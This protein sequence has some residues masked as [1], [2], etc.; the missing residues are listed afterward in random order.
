MKVTETE[1]RIFQ[2]QMQEKLM[3]T[4]QYQ[5]S[6]KLTFSVICVNKGTFKNMPVI[7]NLI[8]CTSQQ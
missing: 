1:N 2:I 7:N 4:M 6:Q 5:R 3:E 8:Q